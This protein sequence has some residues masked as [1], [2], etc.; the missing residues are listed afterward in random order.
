MKIA[1][2]AGSLVLAAGML[3]TS[4]VAQESHEQASRQVHAHQR[5][6]HTK[7]KFV[8]GGAVGGAVIGAKVGGPVGALVGAGVGAGGGLVAHHVETKHAIRKKEETGTPR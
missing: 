4:A 6:H 7:A 8:A 2:M 1:M 3:T 5:R